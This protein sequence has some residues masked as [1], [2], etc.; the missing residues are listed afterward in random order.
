MW[1]DYAHD[2]RIRTTVY[3][4]AWEFQREVKEV[5]MQAGLNANIAYDLS[6]SNT[7]LVFQ[8]E[9]IHEEWKVGGGKIALACMDEND[10]LEDWVR[11]EMN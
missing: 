6:L 5:A 2:F 3:V 9:V 1:E 7:H 10:E 4:N 11:V 8:N